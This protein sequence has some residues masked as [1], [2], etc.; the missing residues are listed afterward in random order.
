MKQWLAGLNRVHYKFLLTFTVFFIAF[1]LIG[2]SAYRYVVHTLTQEQFD[3]MA[4]TADQMDGQLNQYLFNL[5]GAFSDIGSM[6]TTQPLKQQ[7]WLSPFYTQSTT[8]YP[9]LRQLFFVYPDGSNLAL[10]NPLKPSP[11]ELTDIFNRVKDSNSAMLSIGPY[12]SPNWGTTLTFVMPVREGD[13]IKG[14]LVANLDMD[15]LNQW[16]THM[17]NDRGISMLLLNQTHLPILSDIK[18]KHSAY[19]DLF[20]AMG[21]QRLTE[22]DIDHLVLEVPSDK[23]KYL[24]KVHS[25]AFQDWKLVYFVSQDVLFAK[26][27]VLKN[28]SVYVALLMAALILALSLYLSRLINHPIQSLMEQIRSVNAG[29]MKAR[30]RLQRHDEF[31]QLSQSFDRMLGRIEYLTEEKTRIEVLKKQFELQALQAQINPHFLYNTLNSI[32]SLLELDRSHQIPV[33]VESLIQLFHYTLHHNKEWISLQSE[34]RGLDYYLALQNIRYKNKFEVVNRIPDSLRSLG[35]LKFTLQPIVEN[36]IFHGIKEKKQQGRICLSAELTA[37]RKQIV[38]AVE[39]NGVGMTPEQVERILHR[40]SNNDGG[41][42][43]GHRFNSIGLRNVHERCQLYFGPDCGIRIFS[44]LGQGT[45]V[46][47]RYP[48]LH[49]EDYKTGEGESI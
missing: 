49:I 38:L 13:H 4:L 34:I 14:A 18:I 24:L 6:L 47:I 48:A 40:M 7:E 23:Q 26:I 32:N 15:S 30:S 5:H 33:V 27:N 39:D 10:L 36:A 20:D 1:A 44:E 35:I 2:F 42:S 11:D 16:F 12:Y 31:G 41:S 8:V 19:S 29:D 21:N 43:R 22:Q 45:R 3:R 25:L 28:N 46:E 9:S 37:D 17:N